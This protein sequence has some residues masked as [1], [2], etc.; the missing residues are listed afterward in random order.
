MALYPSVQALLDASPPFP[1]DPSVN[2]ILYHNAVLESSQQKDTI[3]K[4]LAQRE[5]HLRSLTAEKRRLDEAISLIHKEIDAMEVQCDVLRKAT[6]SPIRALPVD[7]LRAIFYLCVDPTVLDPPFN[8]SVPPHM[9]SHLRLTHICRWWRRIVHDMP[10]LWQWLLLTQ[11]SI[12]HPNARFCIEQWPMYSSELPLS[13]TI[14]GDPE[15]DPLWNS[16]NGEVGIEALCSRGVSELMRDAHRFPS[17]RL[18]SLYIV[19]PASHL[20]PALSHLPPRAFP[21]LED[22]QLYLPKEHSSETSRVLPLTSPIHAFE[23]ATL[24]SALHLVMVVDDTLSDHLRLPWASLT[25][26]TLN[27]QGPSSAFIAILQLCPR[28]VRVHIDERGLELPLDTRRGMLWTT[29]AAPIIM[30]DLRSLSFMDTSTCLASLG[31]PNLSFI[32]LH[33]INWHQ[34]MPPLAAFLQH[35]SNITWLTLV[36][37]DFMGPDDG[38]LPMTPMWHPLSQVEELVLDNCAFSV[39]MLVDE[40]TVRSGETPVLPCLKDLRILELRGYPPCDP[41]G[42]VDKFAAMVESRMR[43]RSGISPIRRVE[44]WPREEETFP[45]DFAPRVQNILGDG[46]ELVLP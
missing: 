15:D 18:Q 8:Y 25:D 30:D 44:L 17:H 36:N 29:P 12:V 41:D 23:D 26:L 19:L 28:L 7:V 45:S 13:Y 37:C 38:C 35:A 42:M 2:D 43:P 4:L 22:L 21:R 46:V 33:G 27:F 3:K 32:E 11:R 40:L 39:L 6:A 14:C 1:D 16:S 10:T 31:A 24:L 5:A 20:I 9:Q 34:A